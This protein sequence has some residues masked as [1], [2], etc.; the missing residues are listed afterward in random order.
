[1]GVSGGVGWGAGHGCY[2]FEDGAVRRHGQLGTAWYPWTFMCRGP[3]ATMSTC[4]VS[5]WGWDVMVCKLLLGNGPLAASA[6]RMARVQ[7]CADQRQRVRRNP[8]RR[9]VQVCRRGPV[10]CLTAAWLSCLVST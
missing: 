8:S 3:T 4:T 5:N 9:W 7:P 2:G 10:S 1:M 6:F